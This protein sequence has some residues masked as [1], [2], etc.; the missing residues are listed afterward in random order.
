MLQFL[1]TRKQTCFKLKTSTDLLAT[2]RVVMVNLSATNCL[3]TFYIW[4]SHWSCVSGILTNV[5][6][7]TLTFSLWFGPPTPKVFEWFNTV[8]TQLASP[9]MHLSFCAW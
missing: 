4:A 8:V 7:I 3:F 6:P 2:Y 1:I 9:A 5:I